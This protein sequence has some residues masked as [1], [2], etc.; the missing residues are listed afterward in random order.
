MDIKCTGLSSE[1]MQSALEQAREGRL[2]ILREVL[3]AIQ[4]PR[5][6]ISPLAPRIHSLKI[7]PELIGKLIGPGGKTI[8]SIQEESGAKI[9]IEEDGEVCIS[10][11]DGDSLKKALSMVEALTAKPEIGAVYT[12]EVKTIRDFGCFVEIVPGVDG[13]VHVSELDTGFVKDVSSVVKVGDKVEVK[14]IDIDDQ[15]R[16]KLS[17]KV[18][19]AEKE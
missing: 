10:S 15:G 6:E 17:R 7:D 14:I 18:L 3:K 1:I 19:L 11:I 12:G 4:R 2:H 8:R 13:L 5:E 16:I 9:D